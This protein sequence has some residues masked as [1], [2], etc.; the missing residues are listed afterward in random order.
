VNNLVV[1][2]VVCKHDCEQQSL[3]VVGGRQQVLRCPARICWPRH[4][5]TPAM[6][7]LQLELQAATDTILLAFTAIGAI[8]AAAYLSRLCATIWAR[9]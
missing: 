3:C 2:H 5:S 1:T 9:S 8:V 6:L 7:S 4:D